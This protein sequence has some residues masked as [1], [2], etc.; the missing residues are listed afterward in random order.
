MEGSTDPL[1]GAWPSIPRVENEM[2][3]QEILSKSG[4]NVI[5]IAH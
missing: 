3:A 2:S 4:K 1:R 5:P